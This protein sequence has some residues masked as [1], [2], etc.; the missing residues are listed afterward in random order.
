MG[1]SHALDLLTKEDLSE[2]LAIAMKEKEK[3]RHAKNR[4]L[5]CL[6]VLET[7]CPKPRCQQGRGLFETQE[8]RLRVLISAVETNPSRNHEAVGSIPGLA[9]WVK[10]PVLP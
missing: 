5:Y 9:Q 7:R 1:S 3:A 2:E 4:E 10:D 6:T 8:A